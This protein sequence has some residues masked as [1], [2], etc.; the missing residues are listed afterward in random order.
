VRATKEKEG[1]L[2]I[3]N[4]NIDN[5]STISQLLDKKFK[6]IVINFF[7]LMWAVCM[8]NFSPL[9]LKLCEEIEDD[10]QTYCKN[11]K[12]LTTHIGT[13]GKKSIADL[14]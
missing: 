9:A 4:K 8:Q 2:A 13:N 1:K 3:I 14:H 5:F 6:N 7:I 12:F 10:R 11:V